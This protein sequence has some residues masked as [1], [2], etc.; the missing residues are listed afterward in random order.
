MARCRSWTTVCVM[1]TLWLAS[2]SANGSV[3]G[4][5]TTV[6]ETPGGE[7]PTSTPVQEL[8]TPV[9][10][11][12]QIPIEAITDLPEHAPTITAPEK[13]VE[14]T[15][16]EPTPAESG[17]E[18]GP[19]ALEALIPPGAT[20]GEAEIIIARP[21]S[22]SKISSPFRLSAT[23]TSGPNH[24]DVTLSGEDGRILDEKTVDVHLSR[25]ENFD[26][27]VVDLEFELPV[28][29]EAGRATL[30]LRD[31]FGRVRYANS[32][33]LILLSTGSA[34][35]NYTAEAQDRLI[36]QQPFENFMVQGGKLLVTGLI[37]TPTEKPL[38]LTLTDEDGEILGTGTASAAQLE[39]QEYGLFV[40]EVDYN[41][42]QATWVRLA[43]AIQG[44]RVPG[45][46]YL[47][48]VEMVISP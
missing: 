26:N 7:T 46:V 30:S 45:V 21:G 18:E 22:Y 34:L 23:V 47:K 39:D 25:M 31:E 33:E 20:F 16:I 40:G 41:V 13:A 15:I 17:A 6:R 44:D 42:A 19:S 43:V 32:V 3:G 27:L 38:L 36:I 10:E 9:E 24:V 35:R 29:A 37:R 8:P 1:L 12:T 5:P 11:Q 4:T 48:S 2:C 14:T 28:L